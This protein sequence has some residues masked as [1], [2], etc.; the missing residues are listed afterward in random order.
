MYNCLKTQLS[1]LCRSTLRERGVQTR[2]GVGPSLAGDRE[3]GSHA[4]AVDVVAARRA[5]LGDG[6]H[7]RR[8]VG[9]LLDGLH[10]PFACGTGRG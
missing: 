8:A 5:V 7:D 2:D 10:K 4:L 3:V 6:E 1:G 9:E